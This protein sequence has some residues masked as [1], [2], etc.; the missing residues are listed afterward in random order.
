MLLYCLEFYT[1]YKLFWDS[2]KVFFQNVQQPGRVG[3]WV[4]VK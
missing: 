3:S 1:Y 2:G 4:K